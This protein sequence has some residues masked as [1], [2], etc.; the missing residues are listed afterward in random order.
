MPPVRVS[1]HPVSDPGPRAVMHNCG[2][3]WGAVHPRPH[4]NESSLPRVH[5]HTSRPPPRH[6]LA[7]GSTFEMKDPRHLWLR[8]H[9]GR[10]STVT[11]TVLR[12][13]AD[14]WRRGPPAG[15]VGSGRLPWPLSGHTVNPLRG[16]GTPLL[17]LRP[18][19]TEDAPSFCKQ[20]KKRHRQK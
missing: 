5:T 3:P 20:R 2:R 15:C 17:C 14:G 18:V 12:V 11:G 6:G 4:Q 7:G 9:R 1:G 13:S 19:P 10:R 8:R 16:T